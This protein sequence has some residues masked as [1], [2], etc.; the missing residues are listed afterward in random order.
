MRE[1][2]RNGRNEEGMRKGERV[3]EKQGWEERETS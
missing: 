1:G 2:R 3:R